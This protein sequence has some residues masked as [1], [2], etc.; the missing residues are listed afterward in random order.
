MGVLIRG[1][2]PPKSGEHGVPSEPS[3]LCQRLVEETIPA[4]APKQISILRLDTDWYE[5]TKHELVHL[6]TRL[7]RNGI[8]ILD[9]YGHWAGA[10]KAVDEY[11]LTHNLKPFLGRI[12]DTGR[13]YVRP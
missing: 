13:I 11:F 9:D 2:C 6:F 4:Y 8:L 3:S 1:G 10:R 12:D 5:S 7:S